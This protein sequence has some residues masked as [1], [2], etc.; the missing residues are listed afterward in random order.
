LFSSLFF[1]IPSADLE[2]FFKNG[3]RGQD[4]G[5]SFCG[6]FHRF[7][8]CHFSPFRLLYFANAQKLCLKC[9]RKYGQG[10]EHVPRIGKGHLERSFA[11]EEFASGN[12]KQVKMIHEKHQIFSHLIIGLPVKLDTEKE[13]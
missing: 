13:Q 11:N 10:I 9:G 3:L 5:L 8:L 1:T 12:W 7:I 4:Q 6:L 2:L